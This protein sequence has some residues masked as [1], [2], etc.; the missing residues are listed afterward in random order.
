MKFSVVVFCLVKRHISSFLIEL[1]NYRLVY[2]C[3]SVSNAATN[4]D[5]YEINIIYQGDLNPYIA[6]HHPQYESTIVKNNPFLAFEN[7]HTYVLTCVC[8]FE[9]K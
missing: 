8:M 7:Q 9:K 5:N 4:D 3:L 2:F 6:L 1:R